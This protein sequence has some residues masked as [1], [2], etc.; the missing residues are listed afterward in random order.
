LSRNPA[1]KDGYRWTLSAGSRVFPLRE[2]LTLTAHSY[3]EWRPP[4]SYLVPVLRNLTGS[5]RTLRQLRWDRSNL[6][7]NP[8]EL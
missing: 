8:E 7:Q 3:V 1:T 5:Y 4:I 6:R 2:G